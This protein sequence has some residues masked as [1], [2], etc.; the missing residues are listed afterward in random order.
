MSIKFDP[1]FLLVSISRVITFNPSAEVL[2]PSLN[3]ADSNANLDGVL[4][5]VWVSDC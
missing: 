3:G 5:Y 2:F 1:G 4:S